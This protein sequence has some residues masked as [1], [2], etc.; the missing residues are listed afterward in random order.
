MCIPSSGG[1]SYID[2]NLCRSTSPPTYPPTP[3]PTAGPTSGPTPGS[4]YPP[5]PSPTAGPTSGPT[6]GATYPPTPSPTAG[7][8]SGPTPGSTYHPTPSPTGT[9]TAGP[10]TGP[11]PGTTYPPTPAPTQCVERKC[12]FST[13]AIGVP[14]TD[15]S[16]QMRL[17]K[18]C[19]MTVSVTETVADN[20]LNIFDST[21]IDGNNDPDLGAPNRKCPQGPGG[22]KSK[23]KDKRYPGIGRGGRPD[24]P[25]PNCEPQGNVL[26]IQNEL[27]A[28]STPN[29]SKYGGKFTF[30]FTKPNVSLLG[31]GILDID[32]EDRDTVT[33]TYMGGDEIVSFN[34]PDGVGNNGFWKAEE[35]EEFDSFVGV[36][37]MVV[38]MPG[39][40]AIS[41]I[42]I[43]SCE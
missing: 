22:G 42:N 12:D 38:D 14:L 1:V 5:T 29:D 37:S 36:T 28:P 10:T 13:L 32:D 6:P 9:P 15:P 39:S 41:Y 33:I 30:T 18:D 19:Y 8:T 20:V 7:P 34:S 21:V 26:I 43:K 2:Y 35:T 40:G 31:L 24:S 17:E 27:I 23:D 16:Q 11:T 4:T 25:F 3:S